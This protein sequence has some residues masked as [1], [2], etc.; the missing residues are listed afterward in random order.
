MFWGSH[1]G[2]IKRMSKAE[3]EL[4]DTAPQAAHLRV[5]GTVILGLTGCTKFRY[6]QLHKPL[7]RIALRKYQ[8]RTT[9]NRVL[10]IR[11]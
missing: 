11:N 8:D 1:S 3:V 2:L 4:T 9:R 7:V 10:F 5:I 6:S